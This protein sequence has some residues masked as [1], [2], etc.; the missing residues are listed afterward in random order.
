[1]IVMLKR[2]RKVVQEWS[3]APLWGEISEID[4][5]LFLTLP[6]QRNT[7]YRSR[8]PGQ[9]L[10]KEK[11]KNVSG[12]TTQYDWLSCF[13]PRYKKKM[14]LTLCSQGSSMATNYIYIYSIFSHHLRICK[15]SFRQ[16]VWLIQVKLDAF[17]QQVLLHEP[18]FHL[19][20]HILVLLIS[21]FTGGSEIM[22]F[23]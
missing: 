2:E 12:K 18:T 9:L 14:V 10:S 11:K 15:H 3:L 1:M 23:S 5:R 7:S 6:M 20:T 4:V 13:G 8:N 21:I 17:S 16:P 22:S 19:H